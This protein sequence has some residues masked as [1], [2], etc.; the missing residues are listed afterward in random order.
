MA[1]SCRI[2]TRLTAAAAFL[3]L[4]Q[5]AAPTPLYVPPAGLTPQT[6]AMIEGS[7]LPAHMTP[8]IL[9]GQRLVREIRIDVSAIDNAQVGAAAGTG[10]AAYLMTPGPHVI[11]FAVYYADE[12]DGVLGTITQ[13]G[14]FAAGKAYA[15]MSSQPKL[16]I[17]G[18][19]ISNI[20]LEDS[21][22]TQLSPA[23]AMWLQ[24]NG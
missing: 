3:A 8:G 5:C 14:N 6:A 13:Q 9:S 11:S 23:V 16:I 19:V 12:G 18:N 24:I 22:V 17:G 1:K 15:I 10:R 7:D 20:W 4:A 21:T 2:A